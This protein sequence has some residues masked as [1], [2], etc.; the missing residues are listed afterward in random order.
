V[1]SESAPKSLVKLASWVTSD[2]ST[3]SLSTMIA[4]TLVAI[5]DMFLL[6]GFAVQNKTI[7]YIQ[8]ILSLIL[9]K[10]YAKKGIFGL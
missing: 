3:P 5:S 1:S 9:P 2:S 6:F 4:L 7:F 8:D 10:L